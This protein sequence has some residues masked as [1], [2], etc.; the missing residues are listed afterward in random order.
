MMSVGRCTSALRA[1]RLKLTQSRQLSTR[2][3][4]S[5]HGQSNNF[6]IASTIAANAGLFCCWYMANSDFKLRRFLI[7]NFT[8]STSGIFNH[9]RY[10][11]LL[12]SCYS[13]QDIAHLVFNMLAFYS[14]GHS[15]IS[16]LGAGKF[17]ALYLTGG[18]LSSLCQAAWPY[19]IPRNWPARYNFS[20]NSVGLGASG[21]INSIV[22]YSVVTIPSQTIYLYGL[23]PIPGKLFG[24][25]FVGLDVYNLYE[26]D[27]NV[28]N[29]AHLAGAAVGLVYA[30][31]TRRRMFIRR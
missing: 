11:T 13:H 3:F 23:L 12:T 16:I 29:A 15:V 2:F 31:W 26:G 22:M 7:E 9:Q 14:F 1:G 18:I 20:S 5:N 30:L 28:G 10:H 17:L 27:G 8:V 21:A 25:A 4:H 19:V 24:L 6:V